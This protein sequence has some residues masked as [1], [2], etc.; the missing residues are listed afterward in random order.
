MSSFA[1]LN[2]IRFGYFAFFLG[3][4]IYLPYFSPYLLKQGFSAAEVGMLLGSVMLTKLI[5]PPVLGWLID[6]SNQVTRWLLIATSGALL[7]SLLMMISGWFSPGFGWWLFMLVAFGLMWQPLL[8]QMDVAA[9]R[10][11]G[12]RREQYPALRAW[13]SIGFIVSAMV[14]GALIDQFGLF[15]VPTLL[16]LSLLLLLIS[17]TRLPEP[18]G[19]PSVRRHDDAGMVKVLRQPAMLG[20][21]AGHF[22]IHA[23]HG[24]Y[25]AFFSVYLANLG[26]SAAAI[27]A[28]WALGVVAE[29][30]LFFLL[31]RIR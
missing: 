10:L 9:L 12:S 16:S 26:Y 4:G 3:L 27:G 24:V 17:L 22:L 18:D 13:G 23:A 15:L 5:A 25:Y 30:I 2:P 6:R 8:S 21:L 1:T 11:L 7:I 28:L 19:H 20:F 31:P 29:I 14:L